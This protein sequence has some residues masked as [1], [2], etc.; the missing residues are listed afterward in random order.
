MVSFSD[1]EIAFTVFFIYHANYHILRLASLH[2][3]KH[4]TII[5]VKM[6]VNTGMKITNSAAYV[7]L[8]ALVALNL[9]HY[10]LAKT[11]ATV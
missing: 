5:M 10:V 9:V 2:M 1:A 7:M 8:L 4:G 6:L 3:L 11:D